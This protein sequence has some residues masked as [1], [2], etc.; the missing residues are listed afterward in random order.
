M[1]GGTHRIWLVVCGDLW[2]AGVETGNVWAAP[3]LSALAVCL[4]EQ[5]PGVR[6]FD[7]L[8]SSC[9]IE[10]SSVWGEESGDSYFLLIWLLAEWEFAL[11]NVWL[12]P[13][14]PK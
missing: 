6:E 11:F 3:S 9:E 1:L 5:N 10:C 4:L 2:G 14:E 8:F 7:F 13:W 12:L